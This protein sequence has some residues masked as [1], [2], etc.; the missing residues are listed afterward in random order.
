MA[1]ESNS[2]TCTSQS[3][4]SDDDEVIAMLSAEDST[5]EVQELDNLTSDDF[6]TYTVTRSG[7]VVG[8]WKNV[9]M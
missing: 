6:Q 4:S 9:E 1:E 5:D 8:S 2:D 7:G 3:D